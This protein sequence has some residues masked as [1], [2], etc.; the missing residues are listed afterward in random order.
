MNIPLRR[1]SAISVGRAAIIIVSVV[2]ASCASGP[3]RATNKQYRS[4]AKLYA[5]QLRS[6]PNLQA[7]DSFLLPKYFAGTVNFNLRKPHFVIIH[8][9]AQE[10]CDKTLKTFT[11]KKREVSAH[12]VICKDG[13]VHQMLNDY[14]R[15][16]HAGRSKWGTVSDVNSVSIG[17][18][19]DNNGTDSFPQSQVNA[20]LTLLNILKSS[21][22]IPANNFLGHGDIAPDRKVDPNIHFPWQSLA[23]KGFGSWYG[24]TTN[25]TV[26]VSFEPLIALRIIG[27]DVSKMKQSIQAFRRH[28]LK[29]EIEGEL[30][31][32]EKKVLYSL[33]LQLI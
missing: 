6:L 12:Y 8:H 9:T 27:Y 3:Y 32:G 15:A 23:E 28:Y 14:F 11:D 18:E 30:N 17:I 24:D 5:K 25:L 2:A 20:L 22:N 1:F 13:T 29:S 26:P 31:D 7:N 10:S 16:W 19:L 33:M 4:R 21:Y